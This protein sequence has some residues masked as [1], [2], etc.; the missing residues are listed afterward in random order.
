MN[1]GD[2]VIVKTSLTKCRLLGTI[3]AIEEGGFYTVRLPFAIRGEEY[4]TVQRRGNNIIRLEEKKP[5]PVHNKA[6]K[7]AS[8][9]IVQRLE[10]IATN[11]E[12]RQQQQQQRQVEH[13]TQQRR[14]T[15][16]IGSGSW[17]DYMKQNGIE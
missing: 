3:I 13:P 5:V 16:D 14:T 7:D 15:R 6:M 1:I 11:H 10:S 9:R 12:E 4:V 8:K 17:L 2:S